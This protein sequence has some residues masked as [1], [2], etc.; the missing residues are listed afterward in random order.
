MTADPGP[1]PSRWRAAGHRL[2]PRTVRTRVTLGA[3]LALTAIVVLGLTALYLLQRGSAEH[4]AQSQ[5]RTYAIQIEQS[6]AAN[7]TF[8]RPLP[9]FALYPDDQAQELAPD[10]T[11]LAATQ[12]LAGKPALYRL[13]P[14][15]A[16]PVRPGRR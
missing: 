3:G 9:S 10:G 11:V 16:T 2:T 6:A 14:G 7:G 8:P 1:R 12:Y 4:A 13:M 5:L 15:S